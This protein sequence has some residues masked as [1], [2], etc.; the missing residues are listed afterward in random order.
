MESN[1]F[2]APPFLCVHLLQNGEQRIGK[3]IKELVVSN[4]KT[5]TSASASILFQ[6]EKL[7]K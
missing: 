2:S 7:E 5:I 1:L 4:D 6:S 3:V